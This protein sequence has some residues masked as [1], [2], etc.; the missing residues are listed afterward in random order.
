NKATAD[1]FENI[2]VVVTYENG[3]IGNLLYLTQG[4]TSVPKEFL[5]VFGGGRSAQLHNFESVTLFEGPRRR[6]IRNRRLDKGQQE[7]MKAFV[8]AVAAGE[9]MP[10]LLESLMDTSATT[11]AACESLRRGT[12]VSIAEFWCE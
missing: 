8:G 6:N 5:E 11:L 2:A 9:P 3:S 7:E 12:T 4:A 10:I 1:D